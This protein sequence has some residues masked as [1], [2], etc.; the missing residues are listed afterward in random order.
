MQKNK[1][2]WHEINSDEDIKKL[3]EDLHVS[4]DFSAVVLSVSYNRNDYG[5]NLLFTLD[6][7]FY[8]D[9]IEMLFEGVCH[10]RFS[11]IND[12]SIDTIRGFSLEIR[13]DLLGKTRD[14]KLIVWTDNCKVQHHNGYFDFEKDNSIIIARKM[15]WRFIED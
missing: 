9:K 11:G 4:D 12:S 8:S 15:K 5:N 7:N 6:K 13:T 1:S 10:F 3:I 2:E 14:D